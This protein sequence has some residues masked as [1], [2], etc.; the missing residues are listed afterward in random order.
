MLWWSCNSLFYFFVHRHILMCIFCVFLSFLV[1]FA[2]VPNHECAFTYGRVSSLDASVICFCSQIKISCHSL[3]Y[4]VS[5]LHFS[6]QFSLRFVFL[7][8]LMFLMPL[9][10]FCFFSFIL[11]GLL[12]CSPATFIPPDHSTQSA[13]LIDVAKRTWKRFSLFLLIWGAFVHF[14]L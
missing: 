6:L 3:V 4:V 5:F 8:Y 1:L 11:G 14:I 7:L 9:N 13:H 12:W 10:H 2:R